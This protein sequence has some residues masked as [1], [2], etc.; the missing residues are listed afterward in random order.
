MKSMKQMTAILSGALAVILLMAAVASAEPVY[1]GKFTLSS[2]VRWGKATLPAGEYSF[3]L[4]TTS[5][6]AF[7]AIRGNNGASAFVMPI[8]INRRS[9]Q[10]PSALVVSVRGNQATVRSLRLAEAGLVLQYQPTPQK[11]KGVEEAA[12]EQQITVATNK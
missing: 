1:Q 2:P 7:I 11:G 8:E 6:P 10:G 12:T 5:L 3:T 9:L 4:N